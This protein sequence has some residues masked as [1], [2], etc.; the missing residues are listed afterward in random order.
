VIDFV[1]HFD[2]H[3]LGFIASYGGWVYGILFAIIFAETGLVVTPFLPGDSLLFATG[4]VAAR[5]ALNPWGAFALLALAAFTGNVTNYSAGRG[6]GPRVFTATKHAGLF[7][8]L[9]NRDYLDRAHAFF[10]RYGGKAVVL[11]RF[12]PII[13]TFV[14]FVAGAGRMAWPGFLAYSA[15]GATG[16]VGLCLLSG[17]LFGNVPAVRNH[18]SLVTIG[19][20][21]VS[22]LPMFVEYIRHRRAG[23]VPR[24]L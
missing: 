23:R 11:A 13:R 22:L 2:T 19:I 16:W 8:R 1:L 18:F 5:G 7:G 3:L 12:M 14:P 6:V 17:V 9:M 15:A 20:V 24:A 4:A 10:E 21:I